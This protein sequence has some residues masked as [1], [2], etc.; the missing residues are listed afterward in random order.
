MTDVVEIFLH[1]SRSDIAYIKFIFESYDGVGIVRTID[2]H[3]AIIV[4]LVA[5]DF[6]EP[7]RRIVAAIKDR[8]PCVEISRPPQAASDWLL[9]PDPADGA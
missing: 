6:V 3:A 2:P 5:P 4:I 7:A 1:V 9:E 8:V